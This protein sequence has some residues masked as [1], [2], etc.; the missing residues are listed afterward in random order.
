MVSNRKLQPLEL[1]H[2]KKNEIKTNV[3]QM[4]VL[5][6]SLAPTCHQPENKLLL[7]ISA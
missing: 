4:E 7:F 5:Q 2:P 6:L 1:W 3:T